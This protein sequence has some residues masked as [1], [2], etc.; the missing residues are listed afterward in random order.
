MNRIA[1][2]VGCVVAA[3]VAA[4]LV[5]PR[6]DRDVTLYCSV[7]QDQS[8]T[9]VS[10]FEA[11]TGLKVDYKGE[12]EA[13]RSVG[14]TRALELEKGSPRA[15]V[16]WANEIMNTVHLRDL[17]LLA[18]L[19][20]GVAEKFPA[21]WRDP[22]GTYVAFGVRARI[23]LVNKALLPDPKQW[24]TSLDDL[25][26]PKWGGK[27]RGCA[28]AEPL[29]GTTFTHA[30]ATI[31]RDEAKGKAFW[32]AVAERGR[33]GEV[34][35]VK[36]NGAVMQLVKDA[37][38]EI[39]WGL[40]DTDDAHEAQ[41]QGGDVAVVFPDQGEG[42]PGTLVIPNTL[43]LVK[44]GPHPD[45]GRRLLEWLSSEETEARLAKGLSA[46]MP[47]RENVPVPSHVKRPGKDFRVA[48]VDWQ[49]VG[50]KRDDFVGFLK[51][52]FQR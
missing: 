31:V 32:T 15:D 38:N 24:P 46:Q 37:K 33:K 14:I 13:A 42:K 25:L 43:A 18:P 23:L 44:G 48:E 12:T 47:V 3:A 1:F 20:P 8:L 17:G 28:V 27:D 29:T 30:V 2:L 41:E 52:L 6:G 51:G 19:P 34:K 7:D 22:K 49:A 4:F 11:A 9:L 26:D 45:A 35:V 10:E 39:A 36:G 16:L 5:W 21:P 40:T 50:L